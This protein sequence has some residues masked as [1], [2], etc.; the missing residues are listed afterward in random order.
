MDAIKHDKDKPRMDLLDVYGLIGEAKAMTHG[1]KKYAA[2][3]YLFGKGL[4]WHQPYAACLRHLTAWN[5]GEEIDE[6]S[7]LSHLYHAKACIGMLIGLIERGIGH[8]TRFKK[9]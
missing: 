6:E 1:A 8:D 4:E 3:N 7:G 5:M 9:D 2:Y